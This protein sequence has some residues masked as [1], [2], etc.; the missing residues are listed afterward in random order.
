M[1][2]NMSKLLYP[3][4]QLQVE[5]NGKDKYSKWEGFSPIEFVESLASSAFKSYAGSNEVEMGGDEPLDWSLL[6]NFLAEDTK[7][8]PEAIQQLKKSNNQ[9]QATV[10]SKR[11]MEQ[12]DCGEYRWKSSKLSN[13]S[14]TLPWNIDFITK[15]DY[16]KEGNDA[17]ASL[18]QLS[19]ELESI[20]PNSHQNIYSS[21]HRLR[22]DFERSFYLITQ[23][24]NG[25]QQ[26]WG[27]TAFSR[28]EL[29][30]IY[31][32]VL[33]KITTL[34]RI[35]REAQMS[36]STKLSTIDSNRGSC[37]VDRV[38]RNEHISKKML[39]EYMN[40]WLK[41]NWS[42]PYPDE[43]TFQEISKEIGA[44]P[45]IISNWLINA[46]TRKWRPA[47]VKAYELGKPSETLL[48][49]AVSIFE[50]KSAKA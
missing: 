32:E 38:V 12:S 13:S 29:D 47:I 39:A 2:G 8:I 4:P 34:I 46:R 5:A 40:D 26:E 19:L 14:L 9:E 15:L 31:Q 10:G 18:F 16:S 23:T 50:G 25:L 37:S 45:T 17:H 36:A 20:L 48:D 28:K 3:M 42:N 27:M 35:A 7:P 44:S 43:D 22:Q 49:D 24:S 21:Y 1:N 11:S 6:G 30:D 41:A 33:F